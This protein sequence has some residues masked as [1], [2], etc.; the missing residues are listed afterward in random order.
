MMKYFNIAGPCN[1]TEHYMIDAATRLHGVERLIEHKQYFVIHAAR[2]SGKTTY[3]KDL[4]E[5]LN[6][7]GKYY[8]LYCSLES[9]QNI[10][11]PEKGIPAVIRSI[12]SFLKY[13]DIPNAG[14]FASDADY[15]DYNNVLRTALTDYCIQLDKPLL[16]LFD[17]AD[18]LSSD[19]LILFLRQLRAGYNERS[20]TPF[21]HSVALV[22]M[23]NI[24]D[25][26]AQVRPDSE[27]L[28]SAS[29]FNIVA[30]SLTLNNFTKEEIT[31]LY[32]QHTDATGQVFEDDAVELVWQQT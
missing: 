3:L 2:Q 4:T 12:Y 11:D 28:G 13:T 19:T 18:C 8:A 10:V 24:R 21:V 14:E 29:P 27:T 5:R 7:A 26:K 16:I 22:G 31:Q 9:I 32:R 25:F 23:R 30:K 17:E 15:T 20:S 6:V 1:N